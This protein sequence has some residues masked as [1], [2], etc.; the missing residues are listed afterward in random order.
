MLQLLGGGC[1]PMTSLG[2]KINEAEGDVNDIQV[3][4]HPWRP[5]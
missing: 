2:H 3:L 4:L 5:V 1:H